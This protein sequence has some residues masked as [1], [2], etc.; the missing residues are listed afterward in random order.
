MLWMTLP[1]FEETTMHFPHA[2][3]RVQGAFS[4]AHRQIDQVTFDFMVVGGDYLK[5]DAPGASVFLPAP[6]YSFSCGIRSR[7]AR[8]PTPRLPL[9]RSL[10]PHP[11]TLDHRRPQRHRHLPR[12]RKKLDTPHTL[13]LRLTRRRQKLERPLPPLRRRPPRTH[14]PPPHHHTKIIRSNPRNPRSITAAAAE[15]AQSEQSA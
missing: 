3:P 6:T 10:R 13:R 2:Q 4:L 8:H 15:E 11:K 5:P 12:R 7:H 9:L 1:S 14:R